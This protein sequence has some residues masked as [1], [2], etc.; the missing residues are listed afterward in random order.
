MQ[1]S[2]TNPMP[3]S[4]PRRLVASVCALVALAP[5]AGVVAPGARAAQTPALDGT[6]SPR[7]LLAD[8]DARVVVALFSLPGCPYCEVVRR[9]YL[10]HL[11][12]TVPG[13]R[14]AEYVIGDGVRVAEY[15]IGDERRFEPAASEDAPKNPA[16]LAKSLGI[17][18]APTVA[19]LDHDDR[20]LAERLV[21]YNSA[22]FYGGYLDREIAR[23]LARAGE[24]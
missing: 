3:V 16:A 17:R 13:V 8:S 21:G 20:E 15:V 5:L 12:A 6:R 18:V 22:D 4:S 2:R 24:R 1:S 19:F 23:A 11:E 10:R 14:V 7:T 9:N